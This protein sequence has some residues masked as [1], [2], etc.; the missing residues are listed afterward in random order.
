ME[1]AISVNNFS[2]TY[3]GSD[4]PAVKNIDLN[5]EEKEFVV[6]AG[7]SGCGKTTLCKAFVG[8]I[9]HFYSGTYEGKVRILGVDVL[10]ST[11]YEMSQLVGYVF[12]N[13]DNQLVM[14]TVRRDS[15]FGLENM[16]LPREEIEERIDRALSLLG[17]SALADEPV[18]TLSGGQKQKLAIAG[19]LA[20]NPKILVLDEPT[21]YFSPSS[22]L[23]FLE[24][25]SQLNRDLGLTIF[26]VEHRLDLAARYA[27]KLVVM[28]KG[29][30]HFQGD[31]RDLF[32]QDASGLVG[33]NIPSLVKLYHMLGRHSFTLSSL[34][35][36]PEEAAGLIREALGK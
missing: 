32:H 23:Q 17:L 14:T 30:I 24:F 20:M 8:L 1:P 26:L 27:S 36:S 28:G 18:H 6:L 34:P 9:P 31:P 33:I 5:V 16:G 29:N 4:Q 3:G 19:I 10:S 25:L 7:P 2:F 13:P 12:Q 15:A 35:L 11:I 21:A 22:A